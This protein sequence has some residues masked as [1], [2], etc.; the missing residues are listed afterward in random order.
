MRLKGFLAAAAIMTASAA[1]AEGVALVIDVTGGAAD[2]I[3]PFDELSSGDEV[4][5]GADGEIILMHYGTC[6]ETHIVGGG[7][8]VGRDGLRTST[9]AEIAAEDPAPCPERVAFVENA[10]AQGAVVLR[11]AGETAIAPRPTFIAPG[12]DRIE[13]TQDDKVVAAMQVVGGTAEW[14]AAAPNLLIGGIYKL[15]L[16]GPAG[17]RV[18]GATVKA[19]AGIAVLRFD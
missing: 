7:V 9:D 4:T 2:T 18:A 1:A 11:S 15:R 8:V 12:A 3:A 19:Q 13:V 10:D 14:P 17:D 16:T 5:L 6:L